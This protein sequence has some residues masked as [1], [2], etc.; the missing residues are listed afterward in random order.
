M[1]KSLSVREAERLSEKR[2]EEKTTRPAKRFPNKTRDDQIL[3]EK[4]SEALGAPVRLVVG[5]RG[6]GQIV[7]DFADLDDLD[8]IV[9][10]ICPDD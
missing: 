7:V 1:A 4:L 6:K 3:E 8:A 9:A 2:K 10:K 5:R